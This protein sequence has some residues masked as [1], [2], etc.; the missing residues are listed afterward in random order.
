MAQIDHIKALHVHDAANVGKNLVSKAREM[1][2]DWSMT[3]IPWYY[4]RRWSGLL[5]YPVHAVRGTLWDSTLAAQAMGAD[6]VH[7]HTGGLAPHMRWVRKPWVVHLHGTDI[8]TRQYEP[9]WKPKIEFGLQKAA[10]VVYSTPDLR[11]H[12]AR[13]RPDAIYLPVTVR[14]D[15]A[16]PWNPVKNRV[17][18][19]SRWEQ[20]KGVEDQLEVAR[21]LRAAGSNLELIGLDWGDR[22]AEARLAGVTLI[23]VLPYQTYK[24][25][26]A[27][28]SVVVGQMTAML[29][30]SEL[31]ALASGVPV[32]SSMREDYYPQLQQYC[33]N[34]VAEVRDAALEALAD[35]HGFSLKQNGKAYIAAVHDAPVGV[36]KLLDLYSSLI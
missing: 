1:G 30:T 3:D 34:S 35:P 2:Q 27:S 13:L 12:T 20:S 28:A 15:R 8:R 26:L 14:S 21:Q 10:A 19:A 18:F 22:A 32:V 23:P 16:A 33:G 5:R 7:L 11:E 17:I 25:L 29:G 9:L 24:E 36:R 6:V 31:E 4:K